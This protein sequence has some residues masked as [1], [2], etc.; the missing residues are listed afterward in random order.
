MAL[1]TSLTVEALKEFL[2]AGHDPSD[3]VLEKILA[4]A[5]QS[6]ENHLN[7]DFNGD[8]C[9]PDVELWILGRSARLYER[10]IEGL[11][12]EGMSGLNISYGPEEFSALWPY[13]KLPWSAQK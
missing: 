2:P 5:T 12:S 8:P 13:R 4:A 3:F 1:N 9:P 10:R 11:S 7:H 6:A